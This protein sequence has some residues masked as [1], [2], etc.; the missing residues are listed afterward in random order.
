[1][2]DP[3]AEARG[4]PFVRPVIEVTIR[5]ALVAVLVVWCF[6]I[7]RP[8]VVPILWGVIIAVA[9]FPAYRRLRSWLGGRRVAAAVVFT[10][11]ALAVLVVP[12]FMLADTVV[13]GASKAADAVAD[14][15]LEIPPPSEKVADWPLIGRPLSTFWRQA[16]ENLGAALSQIGPQLRAA[17]AWLVSAAA[18]VGFAILQFVFAIVIAGILLAHA[19]EGGSAAREIALRVAGERGLE[20]ARLAMTTVR[21]VARGILGVALIQSLLAGLGFLAVGL[22]AAG[23]LALLCLMLAVVQVGIMP[24]I[25]PAVIYALSTLDTLPAVL[26]TIWCVPVALIDNVLRPILLGRGA[27]VPMAVIFLGAIGGFL[28]AGIIGLFVG[29]VILSLGYTLFLAW[30]REDVQAVA[31]LPPADE[32][33]PG[34]PPTGAGDGRPE[35]K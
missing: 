28:W 24:V 27:P 9:A 4:A 18:G 11:L 21:N 6:D 8:F 5:L 19:G 13:G 26:F 30:L 23:L 20:F 33:L 34:G 25:V 31:E 29:A 14:G 1:M 16:S 3:E 10:G 32:L 2:I 22:P 15:R 35:I 12:S 7:V 17:G